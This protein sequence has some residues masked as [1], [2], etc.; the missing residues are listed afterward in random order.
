LKEA[1][2]I[3]EFKDNAKTG[4]YQCI[5][6]N[7]EQPSIMDILPNH[8][9]AHLSAYFREMNRNERYRVK[10]FVCDM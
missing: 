7:P 6:V 4:K 1:I 2:S 3:D 8:T 10:Y 9:Q 5:I